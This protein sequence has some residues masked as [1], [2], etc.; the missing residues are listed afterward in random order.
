MAYNKKSNKKSPSMKIASVD[1]K[2]NFVRFDIDNIHKD[3]P[4]CI[5]SKVLY[6]EKT[7]SLQHTGEVSAIE[8]HFTGYASFQNRCGKGWIRL[9]DENRIVIFSIAKESLNEELFA[10]RGDIEITSFI[11]TNWALETHSSNI[12]RDIEDGWASY[13]SHFIKDNNTWNNYD[14]IKKNK[15]IKFRGNLI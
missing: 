12:I 1:K 6:N 14:S 4:Q 10:Y 3:M 7:I 8:M 5:T 13:Q 15:R 9:I 2:T 11:V